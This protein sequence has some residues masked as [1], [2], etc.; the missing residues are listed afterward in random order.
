MN[1]QDKITYMKRAISLA[2]LGEGHVNPNPLVGAIIVK[3]GHIIGEGYHQQYGGPHAE[4]NAFN[5]ASEDVTGATLFVTLE[6]CAHYGKTPPCALKIIEK[7]IKKVI[8]AKTDPNPLVN[9]KGIELLKNAGI[10]VEYGLLSEEVERQNEIFL[11][12]IQTKTP[13]VALKYAMTLDGKIATLTHDSKWITNEKS[14]YYVHQLRNRYMAIMVGVNTIIADDPH[15]NTRLDTPSRNPIRIILDPH[16]RIPRDAYV[17]KTALTQPT[18]LVSDHEDQELKARGVQFIVLKSP[19]DLKDL[20]K[21]LGEEKIDSLLIEGG[22]FTHAQALEQGIVD[23]VYT[24]I[25]PKLIG[26]VDA[27]SPVGGKGIPTM[28]Q[29]YHLKDIHYQTFDDDILIEGT[30]IKENK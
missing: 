16:L 10:E 3:D 17:I 15:L 25:A 29:A 9:M 2:S 27:L 19:F 4:V 13:F 11:K 26:G 14:R 8:I 7:K 24:F 20:M 5:H 23:K 18:I 6:P 30:M 12:Y 21:R 28:N 22:A 1:D